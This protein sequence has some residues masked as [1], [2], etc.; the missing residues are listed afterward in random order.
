MLGCAALSVGRFCDL[1]AL[2][3]GCFPECRA[4]PEVDWHAVP[5]QPAFEGHSFLWHNVLGVG[6]GSFGWVVEAGGRKHLTI[7]TIYPSPGDSPWGR[8]NRE[9]CTLAEKQQT[10]WGRPF[11]SA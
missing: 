11:R 8:P 7:S 9:I 2:I 6:D 3:P 1:Q 10:H 5:M 4:L